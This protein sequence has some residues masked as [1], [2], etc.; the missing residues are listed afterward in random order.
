MFWSPN[1]GLDTAALYWPGKKYVDI[2][3]TD[4]YPDKDEKTKP[5]SS[6]AFS[7]CYS[8]FY[9][10]YSKQY[11]LPFAIGETGYAGKSGNDAW[12]TQLVSQ[13][14]CKY[15]NYI[16]ATWFEYNKEK[17]FRVVMESHS[18]LANTQKL[19]LHNTGTG[20]SGC[21]GEGGGNGGGGTTFPA[22]TCKW[23]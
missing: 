6:N 7:D 12:L 15:S 1:Q 8:S 19:L 18:P 4:C 9:N 21:N 5:L 17:D 10:T 11:N 13:D 2:V 23:G 3:G 14:M 22:D 20:K 16:A